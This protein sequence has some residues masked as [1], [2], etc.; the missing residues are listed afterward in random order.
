MELLFIRHGET[1]GNVARRHQHPDTKLNDRGREQVKA[2]TGAVVDFSP[3]HIVT[4]TNLRAVETAQAFALA[5]NITPI[6]SS[7]F[8]ELHRPKSIFGARF[9]SLSTL[10]YIFTWFYGKDHDGG[11]SYQKFIERIGEAKALLEGLPADARVVVVSHSV[12]INL[13]VEH[14]CRNKRLS[15]AQA[16][17]RFLRIL[18]HKNTGQTRLRYN[19]SAPG[20]C[21][22]EMAKKDRK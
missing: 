5:T 21:G 9:M 7:L 10:R 17:I 13:F 18:T 6:T 19:P 15:L 16:M 2:A 11:E 20:T 8:E 22:W 3:T 1:D 4:S 12:F 14:R